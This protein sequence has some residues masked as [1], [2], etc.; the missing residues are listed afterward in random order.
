MNTQILTD[1]STVLRREFFSKIGMGNVRG[2]IKNA[3]NL[4]VH[5]HIP[6]TPT[7]LSIKVVPVCTYVNVIK[8][9]HRRSIY[10]YV[11]TDLSIY[12]KYS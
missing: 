8:T 7:T 4:Q 1:F 5:E 11:E 9:V 3:P 10:L 12:K 2:I 6:A